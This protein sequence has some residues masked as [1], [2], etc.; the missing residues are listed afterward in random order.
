M[1][2]NI[3]KL[4]KKM[5]EDTFNFVKELN[6]NN[7]EKTLLILTV[8]G[9]YLGGIIMTMCKEDKIKQIGMLKYLMDTVGEGLSVEF[10]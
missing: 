10:N 8:M 9:G 7:D 5:I 3:N 6:L 1:L 4:S 2:D